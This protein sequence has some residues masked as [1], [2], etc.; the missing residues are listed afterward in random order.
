MGKVRAKISFTILEG[1]LILPL[2]VKIE[3]VWPPSIDSYNGKYF[4][5]VLDGISLPEQTEGMPIKKAEI[6]ATRIETEIK[7][8]DA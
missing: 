7:A 3:S 4:E 8:L 1:F 2:G 5:I 6:V